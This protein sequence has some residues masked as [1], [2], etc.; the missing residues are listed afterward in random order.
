MEGLFANRTFEG[1]PS[2]AELDAQLQKDLAAD[3]ADKE[4]GFMKEW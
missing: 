1:S 3:L 2:S 4:T